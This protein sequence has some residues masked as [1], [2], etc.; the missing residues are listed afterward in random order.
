MEALNET[1]VSRRVARRLE[2]DPTRL[3]IEANFFGITGWLTIEKTGSG[4]EGLVNFYTFGASYVNVALS[5]SLA[6]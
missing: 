5:I 1:L 3:S 4:F 6:P 2:T